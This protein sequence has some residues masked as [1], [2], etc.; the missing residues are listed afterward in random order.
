[1]GSSGPDEAA[2]GLPGRE[3]A[4][5]PPVQ[6]AY[7]PT[8]VPTRRPEAG[9]VPPTPGADVTSRLPVTDAVHQSPKIVAK[10]QPE[11]AVAPGE[12]VTNRRPPGGPPPQFAPGGPPAQSASGVLRYG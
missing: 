6:P 3:P 8:Y 2:S 11:D 4:T 12:T 5:Q 1:M 10:R 7:Q 9:T